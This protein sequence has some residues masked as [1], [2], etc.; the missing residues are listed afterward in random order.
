MQ[1]R[2][3][4]TFEPRERQLLA[5]AQDSHKRLHLS[6]R[7]AV[8]VNP[9]R[10]LFELCFCGTNDTDEASI[11]TNI[12]YQH[13]IPHTSSA[14]MV[15]L[16]HVTVGGDRVWKVVHTPQACSEFS[17]QV[18]C[19]FEAGCRKPVWIAVHEFGVASRLRRVCRS[20]AQC[21]PFA[22]VDCSKSS[23]AASEVLQLMN[24]LY[25]THDCVTTR[26]S[27]YEHD[28][29]VA[30]RLLLCETWDLAGLPL[31]VSAK[32]T[33]LSASPT[34]HAVQ[35]R[36]YALKVTANRWCNAVVWN[37]MSEQTNTLRS[38]E[39]GGGG[40]VKHNIRVSQVER[41]IFCV[42]STGLVT[43]SPSETGHSGCNAS[44]SG[45]HIVLANTDTPRPS[46]RSIADAQNRID[47][48]A[49]RKGHD[50]GH[51]NFHFVNYKGP[52]LATA[53][54]L[55]SG[56][57]VQ[58]TMHGPCSIQRIFAPPGCSREGWIGY[59]A[60]L[61][62]GAVEDTIL[63]TAIATHANF[64]NPVH[65][66]SGSSTGSMLWQSLCV[67]DVRFCSA[68]DKSRFLPHNMTDL[69][70]TLNLCGETAFTGNSD[71]ENLDSTA[72]CGSI[73]VL[74]RNVGHVDR[75][76]STGH[77]QVSIT[78]QFV[79]QYH[80]QSSM[81]DEMQRNLDTHA[82]SSQRSTEQV[83][84]HM[85]TSSGIV[86]DDAARSSGAN[87]NVEGYKNTGKT[88]EDRNHLWNKIYRTA[89]QMYLTQM[90]GLDWHFTI[91]DLFENGSNERVMTGL[92]SLQQ[93]NTRT[94]VEKRT[95]RTAKSDAK[96][97]TVLHLVA[98]AEEPAAVHLTQL[99][100]RIMLAAAV[101]Q[102]ALFP[103]ALVVLV[104]ERKSD[105]SRRVA[106][107]E[108]DHT[109]GTPTADGAK[110]FL[111]CHNFAQFAAAF[112][113]LALFRNRQSV[114]LHE[115][116][117]HTRAEMREI[118]QALVQVREQSVQGLVAIAKQ[119]FPDAH[120]ATKLEVA[121]VSLDRV[122]KSTG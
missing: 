56:E 69:A 36:T 121:K 93:I 99:Q 70:Q 7:T 9:G 37:N 111:Q 32:R 41:G 52:D 68:W 107:C 79:I 66:D 97:Q 49:S 63:N 62:A 10:Q 50:M 46:E 53:H 117:E 87:G 72:L 122:C 26:S 61:L 119:V 81:E 103:P 54:F 12:V 101:L 27:P 6:A 48:L 45:K 94:A 31:R 2:T 85:H 114:G 90:R 24:T 3:G 39:S 20:A 28:D 18:E 104:G 55:E 78:S 118:T 64:D 89:R 113:P 14:V 22:C 92:T 71:F 98:A 106:Y 23:S 88:P 38:A 42:S 108:T 59:A 16:Q 80:Y 19:I 44:A 17:P 1:R 82:S 116:I 77:S 112:I 43:W 95:A 83:L 21:V 34:M 15:G 33:K 65:T 91:K 74:T 60:M 84:K 51:I 35:F 25:A 8:H 115:A 29:E 40:N 102:E 4:H 105:G 100:D 57:S 96:L 109:T 5:M 58:V 47:V 13:L 67:R 11:V 30:K 76:R 120:K 110:S 75:T 73:S 86:L